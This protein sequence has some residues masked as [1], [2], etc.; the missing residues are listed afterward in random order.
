MPCL[1][2]HY[3]AENTQVLYNKLHALNLIE[4]K[5]YYFFFSGHTELENI[6]IIQRDLRNNILMY[7]EFC[8]IK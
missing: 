6:A 2:N 5:F 8:N 1:K 3:L 4:E 7:I